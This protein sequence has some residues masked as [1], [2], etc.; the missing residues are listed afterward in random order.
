MFPRTIH[1]Y[2]FSW[3]KK[4]ERYFRIDFLNQKVLQICVNPGDL[5]RGR[6]HCTGIYQVSY[7][8]MVGKYLHRIFFKYMKRITKKQFDAQM[9]KMIKQWKQI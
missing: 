6:T 9:K 7:I 4:E 5:H 1:Y 3:R 2:K 8:S